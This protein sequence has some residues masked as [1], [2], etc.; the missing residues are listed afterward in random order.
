[1]LIPELNGLRRSLGLYVPLLRISRLVLGYR[2]LRNYL[3]ISLHKGVFR[4]EL[5]SRAVFCTRGGDQRE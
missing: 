4:I 1:M 2:E 3:G 5:H